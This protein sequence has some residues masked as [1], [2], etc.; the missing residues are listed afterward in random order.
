MN[1]VD[2]DEWLTYKY[3]QNTC[4]EIESMPDSI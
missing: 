2:D 1:N 4:L 3:V